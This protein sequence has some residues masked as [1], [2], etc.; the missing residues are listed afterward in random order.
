MIFN[1]SVTGARGIPNAVCREKIPESGEVTEYRF[2][3]CG[4][5]S[6]LECAVKDPKAY[7]VVMIGTSVAIGMRVPQE[8]TFAALLPSE[9]SRMTKQN[10]ELYNEGMPWRSP[11][12]WAAHFKDVLS[13][14]P[15]L[16]LWI[17]TPVDIE[18]S[19]WVPKPHGAE[20]LGFIATAWQQ[21]KE[22]FASKSFGAALTEIFGNSRTALLLRHMLYRS[23]NQYIKSVL[24]ATDGEERFLRNESNA[25]SVSRLEDFDRD[26]A[27]IENQAKAAGVPLVTVLV[28][29]RAQA[30]MISMGEW[31]EGFDPYKLNNQV[32]SIVV[33][34]GG[35]YVDIFAGFRT[36]PNPEQGYFL[37]D[38]H[39]NAQGHL[40][41]SELLAQ[42]L[43]SG[44]IPPLKA[45]DQ[46]RPASGP[47]R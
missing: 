47:G 11:N 32:R 7:R 20:P 3:S 45:A 35:I 41:V 1:D 25:E 29:D 9:L 43:M 14:E 17:L 33:S 28:P 38:G 37:I 42:Q 19:A 13:A 6:A 4:H 26:V 34:H 44:V 24:M 10:V 39:P 18:R 23:R 27:S 21:T 2:N 15:S 12:V 8:E 22:T 40:L 46:S 16:I 5:R 31:P 30:A 36:V